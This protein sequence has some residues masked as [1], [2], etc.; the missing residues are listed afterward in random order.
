MLAVYHHSAEYKFQD[1]AASSLFFHFILKL[2]INI[3]N[4]SSSLILYQKIVGLSIW[5]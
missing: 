2:Q 4:A 5:T 3:L 1:L